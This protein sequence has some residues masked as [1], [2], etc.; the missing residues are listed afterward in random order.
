MNKTIK[1]ISKIRVKNNENWMKLL[2]LAFKYA[3]EEAREIMNEI[4]QCD[5][6]ITELCE[7]L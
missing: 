1:Q 6:Q 3:P 4:I 2:T 7:K 5:K